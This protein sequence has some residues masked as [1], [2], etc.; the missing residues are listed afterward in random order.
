MAA[1]LFE[2]S[3]GKQLQIWYDV[4]LNSP[5]SETPHPL[6]GEF[7]LSSSATISVTGSANGLLSSSMTSKMGWILLGS[8]PLTGM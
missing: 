4:T 1:V 3:V 2:L 6:G 7:H 8:H 5:P